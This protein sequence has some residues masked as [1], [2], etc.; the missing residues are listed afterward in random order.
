MVAAVAVT[1]CPASGAATLVFVV[2]RI[3]VVCDT[4]KTDRSHYLPCFYADLAEN[5]IETQDN[6]YTQWDTYGFGWSKSQT[7]IK[8]NFI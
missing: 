3:I 8:L 5:R 7:I 4:E 6:G 1:V 2:V